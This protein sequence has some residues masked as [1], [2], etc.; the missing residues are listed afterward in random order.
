[1][2]KINLSHTLFILGAVGVILTS[3]YSTFP[4][5]KLF[6]ILSHLI[7]GGSLLIYLLIDFNKGSK[8]EYHFLA[9]LFLVSIIKVLGVHLKYGLYMGAD[10]FVEYTKITWLLENKVL[11]VGDDLS[12]TPLA[13]IY[14]AIVSNVTGIDLLDGSFNLIHLITSALLPI[15]SYILIRN[16]FN[17]KV[18]IL[19]AFILAYHPTNTVLGMSMTRENLALL[20]FFVSLILVIK[21]L[22]SPKISYLF[23]FSFMSIGIIFAHYTTAYFTAFIYIPMTIAIFFFH[24]R[25]LISNPKNIYRFITPLI[26]LAIFIFFL[27]TGG[28]PAMGP[29][30]SLFKLGSGFILN[31]KLILGFIFLIFLYFIIPKLKVYLQNRI[32]SKFL[33]GMGVGIIIISII[34]WSQLAPLIGSQLHYQSMSFLL[35]TSYTELMY[36]FYA[37]FF[38]VGALICIWNLAVWNLSKDQAVIVV[39]GIA[40]VALAVVWVI[41]DLSTALGPHRALRFSAI[42]SSLVAAI[43]VLNLFR[44]IRTTRLKTIYISLILVVFSFPIT[45]Y[46]TDYMAFHSDPYPSKLNDNMYNI[47]GINEINTFNFAL[48][49]ICPGTNCSTNSG[50]IGSDITSVIEFN[51]AENIFNEKITYNSQPM[52][53]DVLLNPEKKSALFLRKSLL[54]YGQYIQYPIGSYFTSSPYIEELSYEE[55]I[56]LKKIIANNDIL[57]SKDGFMLVLV[58]D[59]RIMR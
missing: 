59:F 4:F 47:R 57:Y 28:Y 14:G 20:F 18:A 29:A 36:K 9:L 55:R 16:S 33:W 17:I 38:V 10:S 12:I 27:S 52:N 23:L 58:K 46:L 32:S 26:F 50:G 51:R 34:A 24:T 40:S 3:I 48:N 11:T 45:A 49:L 22:K 21:Q 2:N 41:S 43:L 13:I 1:M 5:A 15:G 42:L 8:V 54:E 56:N 35:G 7:L 53:K 30:K 25:E 37:L 39:G 31:P 6:F 44:I 19:G